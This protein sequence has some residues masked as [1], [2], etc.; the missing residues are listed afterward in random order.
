MPA[1]RL[2]ALT[3]RSSCTIP[4]CSHGCQYGG[5]SGPA[6]SSSLTA[7]RCSST[8]TPQTS[9]LLILTFLYFSSYSLDGRY[10]RGRGSGGR[11]RWTSSPCAS[12]YL[13]SVSR[14][15]VNWQI[16]SAYIGYPNAGGDRRARR[17]SKAHWRQDFQHLVLIVSHFPYLSN[18]SPAPYHCYYLLQYP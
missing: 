15:V 16:L 17:A 9:S 6:F 12:R 8:G 5:F 2:K 11:A 13:M 3:A 4:A 10:T 7:S 18:Y 14:Q 1:T